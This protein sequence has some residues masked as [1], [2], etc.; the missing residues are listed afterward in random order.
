MGRYRTE[1]DRLRD[2][3]YAAPG[4]YFVTICTKNKRPVFGCVCNAEMI[5]SKLGR[6]VNRFWQSIADRYSHV[7]LDAFVVMPNHL[8]GILILS[9][10]VETFHETSLQRPDLDAQS[11]TMSSISPRSG[12]LGVII[13]SYKGAVTRWARANDFPHF[14]WQRGY[15]APVFAGRTAHPALHSIQPS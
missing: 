2:W 3:D 1:S 7:E 5:P 15:Y 4:A 10:R 8:H 6:M 11:K 12:S 9:E 13:R 14:A